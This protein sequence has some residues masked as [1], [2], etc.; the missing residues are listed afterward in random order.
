[1]PKKTRQ[2]RAYQKR[3]ESQ[4]ASMERKVLSDLRLHLA[5]ARSTSSHGPTEFMD[6]V[7]DGE[8]DDLAA[9]IAESDSLKLDEIEDA[10]D[11]LRQGRY[12]LCQSCGKRI[13]SRRLKARPA[14]TLCLACKK[15]CELQPSQAGLRAYAAARVL[16]EVNLDGAD[17]DEEPAAIEDLINEDDVRIIM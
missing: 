4:L 14:A 11:L 9:R 2:N 1:M 7:S 3:L 16:R 12:G 5:N 8:S 17:V 10:L 15:E 6:V 13:S